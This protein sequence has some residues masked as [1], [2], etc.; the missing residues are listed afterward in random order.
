MPPSPPLVEVE[1]VCEVLVPPRVDQ[2]Y[3]WALQTGFSDGRRSYGG[4]HTGLQWHSRGRTGRAVNWGGYHDPAYGGAE[5]DGSAPAAL[6]ALNPS[7]NTMRYDWEPARPYRFRV[8]R[9]ADGW[10]AEVTDVAGGATTVLRD[11]YV[12]GDRLADP[13]VWSE[14]F[15]RCADP[16]VTVRWSGLQARTADG[17]VVRPRTVTVTYQSPKAG[18]CSNTT[19]TADEVGLLQSTCRQRTVADGATLAVPAPDR[20]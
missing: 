8:F 7:G 10:R 19:V 11:L 13:V 14:V 4:A 18:G 12:R 3:F 17:A 15:A 9:A 2:L 16:S 1:A 6:A 5:L 20:S